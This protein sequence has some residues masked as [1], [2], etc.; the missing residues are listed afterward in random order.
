M[1]AISTDLTEEIKSLNSKFVHLFSQGD[2][3][4]VAD[5]YTITA[6][7]M[8]AGHEA[9][10]GREAICQYWQS[11]LDMGVKEI[12]LDTVEVEQ[13][14]FT[15]IELGTYVLKGDGGQPLD[16]GKYMAVWKQE[17]GHWKMQKDIW[18]S[19]HQAS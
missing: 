10:K 18:N 2:A 1:E 14:D 16:K 19:N 15:A 11:A 9:L 5:L 17:N 6:L 3:A 8:P 13:L 7:L 4:G 12:T